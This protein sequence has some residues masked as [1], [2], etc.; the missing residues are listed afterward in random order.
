MFINLFLNHLEE[1]IKTEQICQVQHWHHSR[2]MSEK[3]RSKKEDVFRPIDWAELS[4]K[5]NSS[6]SLFDT[7]N[8]T[9]PTK[10]SLNPKPVRLSRDKT[11]KIRKAKELIDIG[12]ANNQVIASVSDPKPTKE[13]INSMAIK[14]AGP[15]TVDNSLDSLV[16]Y[17]QEDAKK[18]FKSRKLPDYKIKHRIKATKRPLVIQTSS[19]VYTNGNFFRNYA[20]AVLD[21][22]N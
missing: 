2:A 18:F 6:L 22:Q 17:T 16:K 9:K 13:S 15:V 7:E 1:S 12:N 20:K 5:Q 14:E 4:F 3:R 11:P 8:A 21:A 19:V 10:S